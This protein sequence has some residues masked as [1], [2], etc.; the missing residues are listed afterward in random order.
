MTKWLNLGAKR[1]STCQCIK[2]PCICFLFFMK[3]PN[4]S[5]ISWLYHIAKSVLVSSTDHCCIVLVSIL[6]KMLLTAADWFTMAVHVNNWHLQ[7]LGDCIS[8]W[9]PVFWQRKYSPILQ[10][11]PKCKRC[12]VGQWWAILLFCRRNRLQTFSD[13]QCHSSASV[14]F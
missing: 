1:T 4:L 8:S 12:E 11:Q 13:S 14:R 10:H 3:S 2:F 9:A 6:V 7:S 5:R